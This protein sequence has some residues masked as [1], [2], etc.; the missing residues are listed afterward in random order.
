MSMTKIINKLIKTLSTVGLI[1]VVFFMLTSISVY[2]DTAAENT[3]LAR[4]LHILDSL[5]PIINAAEQRRDPK[6]RVQFRYDWLRYDLK[7]IKIGIDQKVNAPRIQPRIIK[8]L[9]GDFITM[10]G[11]VLSLNDQ[12]VSKESG[13]ND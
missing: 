2:A 3:E 4:V 5:K 10:R 6:A 7:Q 8:P 1:G 9:K 12:F 13:K 11:K